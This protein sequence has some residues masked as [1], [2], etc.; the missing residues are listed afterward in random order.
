MLL[1]SDFISKPYLQNPFGTATEP[2]NLNVELSPRF[3]ISLCPLRETLCLPHNIVAL[4]VDFR[5]KRSV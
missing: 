5:I 3:D 1:Q 2:G 4:R